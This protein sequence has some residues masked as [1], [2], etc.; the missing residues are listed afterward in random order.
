MPLA[1]C[2]SQSAGRERTKLQSD[3]LSALKVQGKGA[4]MDAVVGGRSH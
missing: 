1:S 3:V 4:E 2:S